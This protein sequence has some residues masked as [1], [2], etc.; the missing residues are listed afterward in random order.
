[1]RIARGLIAL[2]VGLAGLGLM[3][4]E[5]APAPAAR[6][7][8]PLPVTPLSRDAVMAR[9]LPAPRLLK[10][11]MTTGS[12]P[13]TRTTLTCMSAQS[14]RENMLRVEALRAAK[15][16]QAPA[17]SQGCTRTHTMT[18]DGWVKVDM[19]CDK[20]KGAART[21]HMTIESRGG[22]G[23]EMGE[24]RARMETQT[25]VGGVVRTQVMQTHTTPLGP[26]PADLKPGQMRGADGKVVDVGAAAAVVV[27][28]PAPKS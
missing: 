26:C 17:S 8:P 15:P 27:R 12:P 25:E 3:G 20:A 23:G 5:P 9:M 28:P 7:A 4:A 18:A 16:A 19:V 21:S 22:A 11:E 24:S 14:A 13:T 10:M 2:A 6:P 1:M